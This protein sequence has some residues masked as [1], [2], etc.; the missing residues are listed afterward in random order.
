MAVDNRF[1][2]ACF[3]V[4]PDSAPVD[5]IEIL[6]AQKVPVIVSPLHDKDKDLGEELL[7]PSVTLKAD[8][9]I[10]LCG[11]TLEELSGA[12]GVKVT[13]NDANGA[14]FIRALLTTDER[15]GI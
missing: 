3:L 8:E 12:L 6:R 14:E 13:P 7:I 10:F 11:M 2:N 9:D 15:Q 1:R 5:W 4:Y